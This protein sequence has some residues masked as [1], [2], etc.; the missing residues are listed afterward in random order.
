MSNRKPISPYP[1]PWP[2][3]RQNADINH[4]ELM[5]NTET[6]E[7]KKR[8]KL[9]RKFFDISQEQAKF[10]ENGEKSWRFDGKEKIVDVFLTLDNSKRPDEPT[11]MEQALQDAED[12]EELP[13]NKAT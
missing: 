12:F 6:F 7:S 1:F 11:T 2:E 13:A 5:L 9:F 10:R 4:P 8:D 3:I